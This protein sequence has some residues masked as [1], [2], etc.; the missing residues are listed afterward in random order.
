MRIKKVLLA[1]MLAVL[2]HP[3]TAHATT[4]TNGLVAHLKFDGDYKD[5]TTNAVDGAA[6]GGTTFETGILGQAVHVISTKDGVTNNY[7]TLNYPAQLQFGSGETGD[8]SD[9]SVAFWAKIISQSDDQ[10]FIGNKDWIS[11]GNKGW[12]I[13]TQG[14]GMKWNLRDDGGSKRHDSPTLAPQ[15][16][17]KNWHHVA[18][19][20][21][22]TN[23]AKIYV[24]GQLLN[25]TS[26]APDPNPDAPGTFFPVGSLDTA[27]VF[28][29]NIGQ[30]G[31]GAYTDNGSAALDALMDDVG[32]WRRVIGQDEVSEIYLKGNAGKT[33]D[34]ESPIIATA[35]TKQP[36][37][38]TTTA[39][40]SATFSVSANGLGLAYQWKLNGN[41]IPGATNS[42]YTILGPTSADAGSYQVVITGQNGN[43]TSDSVTLT[44][45][46]APVAN[47]VTNGLVAHLKFDGDYKDA[48]KVIPDA[49]AVGAPAFESGIIGQA[50]HVI[51]TKEN[52]TNNYVSLN[53]PDALKFGTGDFSFSFWTKVISQ[54]DDK[55]FISNK[56]WD[57]GG[58]L[59]WVL[60]TSGSGMKWNL[61]GA[62]NN[63]RDSSS[64]GGQLNDHNWHHVVVTINRTN[65]GSI[66]VDGHLL[67]SANAAPDA[68]QDVGSIDTDDSGNAINIGQDGTGN[69]ND[70]NAASI[71]ALMDDVGIWNR[72]L[73]VDEV[74]AI[75]A[76]G[77]AGKSLDAPQTV[78][79]VLSVGAQLLAGTPTLTVNG[80]TGPFLVQIKVNVNDT[81][82]MNLVTTSNRSISLPK[83]GPTAFF[84]VRDQAT[85]QVSMLVA[86]LNGAAE[87]PATTSTGTGYAVVS[88]DGN[89]V[90]YLVTFSG[91][92]GPAIAAHVHGPGT[93]GVNAPVVLPLNPLGP[94]GTSGLYGD[95]VSATSEQILALQLQAAYF[96]IQTTLNPNGEI[97]GQILPP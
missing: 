58:N 63:R 18:V 60:A 6:V 16:L 48:A 71:N 95:T 53:Y 74:G 42:T 3:P 2:A 80:G 19:T 11:G 97:R 17:D 54:S 84:R 81:N 51:S 93:V 52:A 64:V 47:S 33:L 5:A 62:G 55:P 59:G 12:V 9:F 39:G 27:D 91:L 45:N 31:T 40:V 38:I 43:A 66:Y 14:G 77:R 46:P 78:T 72:V 21:Q 13:A 26:I 50:V 87:V 57:A 32:I 28:A 10:P 75:A 20:F 56:N 89:T 7:V 4:V 36:T 24:D 69:Y 44:V 92:T 1:G 79:S 37:S 94:I 88:I 90:S 25:S 73:T 23:V 70:G 61:T 86:T 85:N 67:N 15:L 41:G 83:M 8:A 22:R 34:Q 30:D 49:V 96:N 76:L 65:N 29:V 35:I 68:G 82:W